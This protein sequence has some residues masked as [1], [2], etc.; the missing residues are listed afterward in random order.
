MGSKS[1]PEASDPSAGRRT[2]VNPLG[3]SERTSAPYALLGC[4]FSFLEE[5]IIKWSRLEQREEEI[6]LWVKTVP[7]AAHNPLSPSLFSLFYPF[8]VTILNFSL[9]FHSSTHLTSSLFRS[10]L[11]CSSVYI[12]VFFTSL[13]FTSP[14]LTT[15]LLSFLHLSSPISSYFY[16]SPYLVLFTWHCTFLY[17]HSWAVMAP[18]AHP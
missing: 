18:S 13:H 5:R 16:T 2:N 1:S 17:L 10:P 14:H 4:T 6:E 12:S 11:L 15:S 9:P 3:L 8:T 7:L